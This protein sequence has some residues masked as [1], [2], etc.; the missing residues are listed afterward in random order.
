MSVSTDR[1]RNNKAKPRNNKAKPRT[2]AKGAEYDRV[3]GGYSDTGGASRFFYCPK[4]SKSEKGADNNHPTVKPINLM[5]WLCRMVT[6]PG[7]V[8]LDPFMG[9][10]TTGCAAT[11]EGLGFIGIEQDT[12]YHSIATARIAGHELPL[13]REVSL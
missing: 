2:A 1:P 13:L 11:L 9:S 6:P 5:R 8:V 10:G 4:P 12:H 3:G 7:G